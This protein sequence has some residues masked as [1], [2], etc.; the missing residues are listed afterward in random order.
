M[1]GWL[2]PQSDENDASLPASPHVY[3]GLADAMYS[4][5]QET[6][7]GSDTIL[8]AETAP[9]GATQRTVTQSLPPLLFVRELFCLNRSFRPFTGEAASRRGCP[10][11]GQGFADAHP[12]LFNATGFAHHPY[13][14]EAPPTRS[15]RA[16]DHVVLAD[17]GRLTRTLDRA[18]RAHGSPKRY[19][20]W[21]T[22]YGY[23]SDPPD[24][25]VGWPW[26]TQARY[27]AAAEWLAYRRSRV[28]STAQFLLHDD[29]PRIDYPPSDPRH[30]GTFQTGLRTA[31]GKKKTAYAG[32]QRPIHVPRRVRRGSRI[33]VFGLYRPASSSTG[34]TVQFRREGR[35]RAGGNLLRTSTNGAGFVAVKVR[36]R[37]S[38]AFRIGFQAGG[39]NVYTR[40]AAVSVRR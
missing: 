20:I 38:G 19:K 15:D 17:L 7:H 25:Y 26:R 32:Y 29:A 9:R 12:F 3:R 4:A 34:V 6:G 40:A 39:G 21:L 22:E 18:M 16:R 30:W 8:L 5:L 24:P 13:A 27:L 2:T 36:A 31:E 33:T 37:R 10:E 28:R 35:K 1:P 11:G 23:Q 14:F